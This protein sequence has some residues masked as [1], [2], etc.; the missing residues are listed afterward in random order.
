MY[1]LQAAKHMSNVDAQ[2]HVSSVHAHMY[3]EITNWTQN[4]ATQVS[5]T[6]IDMWCV[7]CVFCFS[8]CHD[9]CAILP[10]DEARRMLW[11]KDNFFFAHCME[12]SYK[13]S[14]RVCAKNCKFVI[15][16]CAST[17]RM[18]HVS[19]TIDNSKRLSHHIMDMHCYSAPDDIS[20]FDGKRSC[21][22]VRGPHR[23][24]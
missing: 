13:V 1:G 2:F 19:N 4:D 5:A 8:M 20:T 18:Q 11:K 9:R 3:R 14:S 6:H 16:S 12:T 15:S 17:V 22:A 21:S 24:H 10:L 7:W 23:T